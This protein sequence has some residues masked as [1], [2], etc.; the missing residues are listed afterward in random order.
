[1]FM[2]PWIVMWQPSD[3]SKFKVDYASSLA[4]L[5]QI[6]FTPTPTGVV[7]PAAVTPADAATPATA[8]PPSRSNLPSATANVAMTLT[9]SGLSTGAKA[10]IGIGAAI[11][12]LLLCVLVF[13]LY[14]QRLRKKSKLDRL[15]AIQNEQP[16]LMQTD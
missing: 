16:E 9:S 14:R 7:T 13:I 5:L 1:M 3:L 11:G 6:D 4:K 2:S 8:A 15:S 10:G 12:A